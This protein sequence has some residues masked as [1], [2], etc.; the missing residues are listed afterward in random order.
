MRIELRGRVQSVQLDP[1]ASSVV[2]FHSL[3]G[4]FFSEMTRLPPG[5]YTARVQIMFS[6]RAAGE[7]VRVGVRS[8]MSGADLDHLELKATPENALLLDHLYLRFR[9]AEEQIIEI[10]GLAEA[11]CAS[12]LLR[13]ITLVS[14]DEGDDAESF[15]L[16]GYHKPSIKD[17]KCVIF[18]TTAVCNASCLH[19]PT[20]KDYRRNFPHGCMNLELFTKILYE[21]VEGGFPGWFLFGLF[22]EPLEDP[23][24]EARLRLIK[25]LLP[26]ARISIATNCGVYEPRKHAAVV[27]LADDI[28]VH[29]EGISPE[30]YDRFMH[31]LKAERVFPKIVSLLSV[32]KDKQVHITTPVHK[33]NL[34]ELPAIGKYFKGYGAGEPHFTQISNR[35]WED[36]PWS[37][38]SLLPVGGFCSPDNLKTFVVDWD[39]AVLG[40]CQDFSKSAQLG[41]LTQQSVTEVLNGKAWLELFEIHRT[42]NWCHKE[43]CRHCRTDHYDSVQKMIEPLL[44]PGGDRSQ[45]FSAKSFHVSP[46]VLRSAEGE[47]HVG[48]DVA[49]G[50]VVYGPYQRL[51]PGRYRVSHF[52]D[53]TNISS[54]TAYIELDI[55]RD[56]IE[57]TAHKRLPRPKTGPLEIDLDFEADGSVTEFRIAKAGIEFVHN[58]AL[59]TR[60]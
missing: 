42:K 32:A 10:Y 6:E 48:K 36:G 53:I 55:A 7:T 44:A 24:L 28:G 17:L 12:T 56:G 2:S 35:S 18:G 54:G 19:C 20:N 47:I 8:L 26:Q 52:F 14:A 60:L 45:R 15:A 25:Q 30:V 21:L 23:L 50:I 31:P 46:G 41:D 39:G 37:Q 43:A 38:L 1:P 40:C 57:R 59:V 9:L 22:G 51:S 49:D 29:V 11:N 34:A 33:G 16:Q 58:G 13:F 3:G 5:A 27:A 4:R